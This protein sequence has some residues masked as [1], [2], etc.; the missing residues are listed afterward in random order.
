MVSSPERNLPRDTSECFIPDR[1]VF[2]SSKALSYADT[3]SLFFRHFFNDS[4]ETLNNLM[5]YLDQ[6]NTGLVDYITWSKQLTPSDLPNLTRH[7]RE[8]GPLALATPTDEELEL[9]ETMFRRAH[10][11]AEEAVLCG[12][13][14]LIDAEQA[15]FQPAIDNLV[16]EL[17]T[18]YNSIDTT[19]V[20]IIFN[21]YQCYRKGEYEE[22][23]TDVERSERYGYHFGAKMVRGAYLESER[24]LANMLHY[25][26]PIHDSL[27]DTHKCYNDSV[28]Y[29]LRHSVETDKKLE[30]MCATHNQ[31]SIEKAIRLMNE[32]GIEQRD[33][34]VHF[35]Q[36]YGMSDNLTYNLGEE[37]YLAYKYV[38]YGKVKEVMPYLIRRAQ[39]NSSVLGSATIELDLLYKE[40]RRRFVPSFMK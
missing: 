10:T 1:H 35:G 34:T 39:E 6:D 2:S 37:G 19:D 5:D 40:M 11:I 27:Q 23:V 20:P 14:V 3:Q 30:V 28:E 36:L 31:E 17:Q 7:C 22:I 26:S 21:T 9:I 29:L 13:R 12:T 18:K 15:R 38:P 4:D 24:N 8:T 33:G 25:P 32:L 16:L